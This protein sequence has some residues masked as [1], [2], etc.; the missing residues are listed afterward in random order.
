MLSSSVG[1][2]PNDCLYVYTPDEDG[3][4]EVKETDDADDIYQGPGDDDDDSQ[5][6]LD[7]AAMEVGVD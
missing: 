7:A 6:T 1:P 2:T 3:D 4:D 5:K